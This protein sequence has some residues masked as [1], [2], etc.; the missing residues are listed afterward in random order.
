[1]NMKDYT[2][3]IIDEEQEQRNQFEF[4][5]SK[6]FNVV[7]ID[8]IVSIENLV[9]QIISENIDAV[10]IDYRLTEHNSSF[11]Q[12]GDILF[13]EVRKSLYEYPVFILTRSSDE[14]KKICKTVDPSFIIDKENINFGKGEQ[15]KEIK[16][17]ESIKTKVLVY[18]NDLQEKKVKLSQ[19][20]DL[21]KKSPAEFKVHEKEYINL[22]FELGK[23]ISGNLPIP[24]TY[25]TDESNKRL[26]SLIEKTEELL[27]K[28]DKD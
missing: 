8:S 15:E 3:A 1:M 23:Y 13:K 16:F 20:E 21:R 14:V 5:F 17:L 22:N 7:Q 4:V 10:A 6:V 25:F 28:L 26:D 9:N 11:H 18:K 12:N 24:I 19:L 2:I 27:R